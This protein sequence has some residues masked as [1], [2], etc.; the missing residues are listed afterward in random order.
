MKTVVN[1]LIFVSTVLNII[2]MHKDSTSEPI[3]MALVFLAGAACFIFY[4]K[5]RLFFMDFRK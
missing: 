2:E 1:L 5:K 3:N 4:N